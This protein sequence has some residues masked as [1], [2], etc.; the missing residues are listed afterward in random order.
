LLGG[1]MAG[2]SI[3]DVIGFRRQEYVIPLNLVSAIL[4]VI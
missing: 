3:R 1:R 2:A 4:L